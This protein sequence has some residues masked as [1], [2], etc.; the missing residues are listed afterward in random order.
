MA[1]RL[2]KFIDRIKSIIQDIAMKTDVIMINFI[3]IKFLDLIWDYYTVVIYYSNFTWDLFP[4]VQLTIC[5][6]WFR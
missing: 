4:Q 5:Q 3:L 2:I 6:R 1:C